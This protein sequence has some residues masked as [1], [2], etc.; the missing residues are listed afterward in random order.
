MMGPGWMVE[1]Q[2]PGVQGGESSLLGRERMG[3]NGR[4]WRQRGTTTYGER[5]VTDSHEILHI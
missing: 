4:K 3:E 2:L 1:L 5:G